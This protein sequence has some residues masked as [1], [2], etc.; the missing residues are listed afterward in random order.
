M[1]GDSIDE[2]VRRQFETAWVGGNP[3]PIEQLLPPEND[4]RYLATLEE[5]VHIEIEFAWK[6]WMEVREG[7][8]TR[9]LSQTAGP[10]PRVEDYLERFPPLDRPEIVVRLIRQEHL[11]RRQNGD[12]PSSEEY[13]RRFPDLA[14]E[15]GALESLLCAEGDEEIKPAAR[16]HAQPGAGAAQRDLPRRLGHYELL[17]EI[18]RGGMGVV[19]RAR[20]LT[21]DRIVALK[22]IRRDRLES[23]PR[24]SESSALDRFRHE[25]QAAARLE[26]ENIVTVYEVGE[27][28]GE[29]FFSMQYVAG[30]SLMEIVHEGPVPNR[31]A[32]AYLEPVARGVHLA[33]QQG[34]LHRDLKPQNLLVD[35]Q[36]DRAMVADFGLAKL[37][38]SSEELTHAGEIM[39][40]PP[41][42]SPEQAI[43]SSQV[44]AQTDVYALGATLYHVLTGRPPFQAATGLE[45]VR[46]VVEQE[47]VPPRHLN[48]SIDRDLETIC[49]EC[50]QKEPSRRYHS[51]EALAD[52]LRRY[53]DG[54]PI[55]ARPL[56]VFGRSVRWCRRNPIVAALLTSTVT[57][58]LLA[59]VAT[60]V[61]Y[62]QTSA[63]LT[64]AEAARKSAEAALESAEAG[65]RHA[66]QAVDDFFT[67]VSEDTLLN[68]PGMQP[69]RRDLL[70]LALDYYQ[71]FLDERRED[72][73]IAD[74]L[75]TAHFRIGRI[76][77]LIDSPDKALPWYRHALDAQQRLVAE[78]PADPERLEALSNTWNALGSVLLEQ[79]QLDDAR[80]AHH[81]AVAIRRR[82]AQ[83]AP[84]RAEFQ[85]TLAN[86]HM[87][88]GVVER[89][90]G[91]LE[92]S[93]GHFEEAQVIRRRVLEVNPGSE[94]VRRDLGMGCYNLGNLCL[95]LD[96][97]D[98]EG[99]QANFQQA[100][101][102]FQGLLDEDPNDLAN[103]YRLAVCC[104]LLAD[105]KCLAQEEETAEALYH[106]ALEPM[107]TLAQRN[108]DVPDYQAG[109]ARLLMNLGQLH[110]DRDRRARAL[111]SFG[112]AV[113]ILEQLVAQYEEVYDYRRDLAVTLR[114][115]AT[116]EVDADQKEAACEHLRSA[117]EHFR[118]LIDR[119]PDDPQYESELRQTTDALENMGQTNP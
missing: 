1:S 28:E 40:S 54:R 48:P 14:A 75:A 27:V 25:A 32:A 17:E 41:Y 60:L 111:E 89:E 115:I 64:E 65:Y 56:G 113:E 74:E 38:E 18:G 73:G 78:R 4:P 117:Q 119:F 112:R 83:A 97:R 87:N 90:A 12:A 19:Y 80:E 30:R 42:M 95:S 92:E 29:P 88:L 68:Q 35:S 53:L 2:T 69:L 63:A 21:A 98:L 100:V 55:Q 5:L 50:L 47:P 11:V 22:V 8:E 45:T 118:G 71:Q 105:L 61:G 76:T 51:A 9:P 43:D 13:R 91:R 67:R 109:L 52:D 93:R 101:S 99:A 10:L 62:V 15:G 37:V 110:S 7:D 72:P 66:R 81:E 49:L 96:T 31:R 58:L 107:R 39:G 59:L 16:P 44:T 77:E 85:R 104:Q 23:L 84:E 57:C 33:H 82:L 3:K 114:A 24:D 70:Q 20:Q 6:S 46:Q 106:Q 103:H 94:E 36:T 86:S 102:L 79:R 26:H 34:I 116:L 108:P